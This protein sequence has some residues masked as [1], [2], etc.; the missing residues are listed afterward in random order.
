METD[1]DP[2]GHVHP[3]FVG[4]PGRAYHG[5]EHEHDEATLE[6]HRTPDSLRGAGPS[7]RPER[8]YLH[9]LLLHLDRLNDTSLQYLRAA[10][11]EEIGRRHPPPP[12]A[13]PPPSLPVSELTGP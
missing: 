2:V 8:L 4:A 6:R 10:L 5:P 9:Y 12:R 13:A 1:Y 3:P 11:E 7:R